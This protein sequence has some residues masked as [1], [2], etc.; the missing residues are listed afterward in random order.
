M[1]LWLFKR[2]EEGKLII[3][4]AMYAK[5]FS[6]IYDR[7]KCKGCTLCRD[8]CPR[9]AIELKPSPKKE[10]EKT[11]HHLVDV[12]Q[13]KCDFC[14]MCEAICPFGAVTHLT[15]GEPVVAVVKAESFPTLT[16]EIAID[17]AKCEKDCTKCADACPI[18]IVTVDPKKPEV[19]IEKD[20]C[21][22]CTWCQTACPTNAIHV[23]KIF[24]G[25]VKINQENC[26]ENCV[27]C[28]DVCPLNAL[29]LGEDG[30]VY[31][32]DAYCIYCGACVNVCPKPE[33]VKVYRTSIYHTPVKSGAW[34]KALEKL[35]STQG[36][37]RELRAKILAKATEAVKNRTT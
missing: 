11:K 18:K 31:A 7:E 28:L 1:P 13:K 12:D 34:N 16:R 36:K 29:H 30:K 26:P 15:N 22:T 23:R 10:G 6:L 32:D 25:S 2:E 5:R 24:N 14:G 19:N 9:E 20:S 3:E 27:E 33:A 35:T 37:E 8:I 21:P 17:M 4:R